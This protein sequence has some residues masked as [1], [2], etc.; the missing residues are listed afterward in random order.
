MPKPRGAG[1]LRQKVKFQARAMVD[2][3]HGNSEGAWQDLDPPGVRSCALSATRGG[4]T[5]QAARLSGKAM[6]DVWL[7]WDLALSTTAMTDMRMVELV[8]LSPGEARVDG[9]AF[10]I[11]FGPED[12]DGDRR[13]LLI[14]AE[15]GVADT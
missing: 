1:D 2:D 5:V 6:F 14:Q 13:W 8:P 15:S 9:R 7:R 11:R 12:I 10:N 4:E 3:G